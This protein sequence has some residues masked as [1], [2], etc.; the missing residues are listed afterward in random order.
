MSNNKLI[1][2]G[3]SRLRKAADAAVD[4]A[5]PAEL[6]SHAAESASSQQSSD[7]LPVLAAASSAFSGARVLSA[8]DI[9]GTP[10]EQLAYVTDRLLEIDDAGKRAEDFIVLNKAVLLEVARERELHVVAGENNFSLWAA[11]VLGIQPKYVFELLNDAARI[12]AVSELGPDLTQHL[13]R[14][15][16]RKV[17]ADVIA[18][19]GLDAAQVV[20]TEG[21]AQAT[22][23]GLKR[24]TASLLASIAKELTGPPIPH[25][26]EK[27]SGASPS[28]AAPSA[29]ATAIASLERAIT[30]LKERVYP[31]LAPAAVRAAVDADPAAA[32][33]SVTELEA[34]LQR[35]A[36]RLTAAQRAVAFAEGTA[37]A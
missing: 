30:S 9:Q 22:Q 17:M 32:H 20:M 8:D 6:Q 14:A 36:K 33:A 19:Q 12:R 3:T 26:Q 4:P 35:V 11:G 34:E 18:T 27:R 25:Q 10:E 21:V 28:S 15:S 16:A 29:P 23:Q 1:K 7:A 24:P 2:A 31:A 5:V 13:T 37:G